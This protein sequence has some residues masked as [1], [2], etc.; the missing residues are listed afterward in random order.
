[1]FSKYQATPV[2]TII[3]PADVQVQGYTSEVVGEPDVGDFSVDVETA[4]SAQIHYTPGSVEIY[5]QN[6][7]FLRQWLT[8]GNYDIYA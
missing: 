1:M 7:G 2:F 5:M 6:E 4:P 3:F 8:M